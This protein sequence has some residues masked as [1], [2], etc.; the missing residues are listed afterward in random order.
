MKTQNNLLE[1]SKAKEYLGKMFSMLKK[2]EALVVVDKKAPFNNTE[3]RLL[4][5]IVTER[6]RGN[7]LISTELA[8]RLGVTR[9]AVSQI[10]NR[11]EKEGVLKRVAAE[12]DKKIAYVEI[13]E[14]VVETYGKELQC[15]LSGVKELVQEF[16]EE[17][18]N[19]MY[20]LYDEFV[21]LAEERTKKAKQK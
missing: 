9:S 21:T 12:N 10:V 17:K 3:I 8:R 14:G 15:V 11:L 7:R 16:G 19:Q 6:A 5:E 20:E 2:G 13:S 1:Q 18:F 4:G